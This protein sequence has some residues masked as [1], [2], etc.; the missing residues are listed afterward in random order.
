MTALARRRFT[1]MLC[2]GLLLALAGV[3]SR[4]ALLAAGETATGAA[5]DLPKAQRV[6][7]IGHSFHF[8]MPG[9]LVE[10]ADSAGIADHSQVGIS[11]IGGSS[12]IHHWNLPD[13]KFKAKATLESGNLDVLTMAPAF[14]PDEGIDNF[15][16]LV[17][18]KCPQVRVLI[19]QS[20]MPFDAYV[21][22]RKEKV[23]PP[24]RE[25]FDLK[26]LQDEH[27]KAFHDTEELIKTLREKYQDKPA[28]FV[29]PVG[30]AVLALRKKI[31]DGAA[32]GLAKQNDLFA[33]PIGHAKPPLAVLVA[34]CYYAEI[35]GNPVGLPVPPSLKDVGDKETTAKLNKLLQ[36]IAWETVAN[37][38][39]SGVKAKSNGK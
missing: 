30:Q 28:I 19:Q 16:R 15:L 22:F 10:L 8:F 6:Y 5:K 20:W 33:D 21:D 13:D 23:E 24:D 26:K 25:A 39:L 17:S 11:A 2:L 29:V 32:P 1:G 4:G 37:Y 34:Y 7:T 14:L 3:C 31:A 36:E 18:E 9:I 27:D 12:L 35:Y 38:P